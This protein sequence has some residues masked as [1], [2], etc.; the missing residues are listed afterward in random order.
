MHKDVEEIRACIQAVCIMLYSK[1]PACHPGAKL[2]STR[3]RKD[4]S[5]FKLLWQH[6]ASH[7]TLF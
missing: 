4:L 3:V 6:T 7:A 1:Y 5:L 2:H